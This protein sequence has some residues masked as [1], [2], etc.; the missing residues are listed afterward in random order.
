MDYSELINLMEFP[1]SLQ[2]K[3]DEAERELES[4]LD[5]PSLTNSFVGEIRNLLF[6]KSEQEEHFTNMI[7]ELEEENMSL[8]RLS[9]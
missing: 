1:D 2:A 4:V 5:N 3:I 9:E 7:K 8:V 6:I